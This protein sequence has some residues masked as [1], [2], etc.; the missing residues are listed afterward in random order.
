MPGSLTSS[1]TSTAVPAAYSL[2]RASVV[3]ALWT[4]FGL[5]WSAPKYFVAPA[6]REGADFLDSVTYVVPFYWTWAVLTPVVLRLTRMASRFSMYDWRRW[7]IVIAAAAPVVALHGILYIGVMRLIGVGGPVDGALLVR[8]VI[9]HGSGDLATY[10]TVTGI[11]MLVAEHRLSSERSTVALAL[12]SRV[13]RADLELLRW[14][15]HPHFLFNAL[16]TVSTLVLRGD[17]RQADHAIQLI[18]RYLRGALT[19]RADAL[20]TVEDELQRVQRYADI[21]ALRFGDSTRL[22]VELPDALRSATLPG[23]ILQPLVENAFRHGGGF[24]SL[25]FSRVGDRLRIVIMDPGL[26]TPAE[27]A[28]LATPGGFGVAY[29]K[30]R[31][32]QFYDSDATF[33]LQHGG[34]AGTA[35]LELPLPGGT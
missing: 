16:N 18:S 7:A 29:V 8:H 19:E 35:T 9:R 34:G 5:L 31:L 10:L 6:G 25:A 13:A 1:R 14:Q 11:A 28:A 23:S 2:A 15:L 17:T 33:S 21:E 24:V 26:A 30:E 32:R 12:E 27:G 22:E 20:V 3:F 4:I